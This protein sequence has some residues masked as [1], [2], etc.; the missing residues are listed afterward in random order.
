M[1]QPGVIIARHFNS[2]RRYARYLVRDANPLAVAYDAPDVLTAE[3]IIQTKNNLKMLVI[4]RRLDVDA[5]HRTCDFRDLQLNVSALADTAIERGVMPVRLIFDEAIADLAC[6]TNAIDAGNMDPDALIDLFR[7]ILEGGLDGTRPT[8]ASQHLPQQPQL[9][10]RPYRT[11]S[12]L[13]PHR[14]RS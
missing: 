6:Q 5:H 4:G 10:Q 8:V 12:V 1:E 13:E 3:R 2:D 11:R 9:Q 7:R 14:Q